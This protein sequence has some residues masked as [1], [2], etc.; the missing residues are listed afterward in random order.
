MMFRAIRFFGPG[1]GLGL[2]L[3]SC[4]LAA[5]SSPAMAET[6]YGALATAYDNNPTLNAQRAASRS[7]DES[8]TIAKS[9]WRPQIFASADAGLSRTTTNG[10]TTKLEP[11]GFGVSVQQTLWDS[12]K[13]LNNVNAARSAVLASHEVLRNTEQNVLFDAASAYMNVIRD[14]AIV[15]FRS[16]SVSFLDEQ[17]RSENSRFEVGESTRT[18]VAQAR[19]RQAGS[20]AQL[21]AAR[22]NLRTSEAVYRQIIGRDPKRLKA[23][24]SILHLVPK[25]MAG[26]IQVAELEHPAI[27][28]TQHLVDQAIF[29]VKSSESD[30]LPTVT[31]DGSVARGYDRALPNTTTDS[32]SVSA[33]LRVPIYQGGRVSGQVRQNKETLG[34]RRIEV[35]ASVDNVRAAVVSAYSQLEA[36]RA[37]VS[38]NESQL[39]AAN[40]ALSGAVE[41]RKVGQRTT[42][43]VL[44]T[45]Q[46]VIDAQIQLANSRRDLVVA[47]YAVVSAIGRLSAE[48]LGL[49]V[50]VYEPQA[51]FQ[52]V[53]DKWFGLRIPS[54]N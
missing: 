52:A 9:G 24:K 34:Q 35:D 53:K 16:Q 7:V 10:V 6:I 37:S 19:A 36:A 3:A 23:G 20:V 26:A 17:V 8:V 48:R 18:D 33:T 39:A 21:S 54:G 50:A 41:E 1:R 40:L 11:R 32:A 30:L 2:V 44:N 4:L 25:S 13:T 51:H 5:G 22:A 28:S 42:L 27:R 29:N 46:T 31:L 45:Q 15:G 38:A 12:L 43:D 14:R 47:S 49:K